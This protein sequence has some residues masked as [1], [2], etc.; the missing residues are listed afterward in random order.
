MTPRLSGLA[1]MFEETSEVASPARGVGRPRSSSALSGEKRSSMGSSRSIPRAAAKTPRLTGVRR[2][3]KT[4][5]IVKS[6][7]LSGVRQVLRS[8][9]VLA[10]PSMSG[11][12]RLLE[13]PKLCVS[14]RLSG[15]A[16]LLPFSPESQKTPAAS[17]IKLIRKASRRQMAVS[18]QLVRKRALPSTISSDICDVPPPKTAK[19]TS[20]QTVLVRSTRAGSKRPPK[21]TSN[22]VALPLTSS[23]ESS[24]A[25]ARQ[26]SRPKPVRAPAVDGVG[27]PPD[28]SNKTKVN[29][30]PAATKPKPARKRTPVKNAPLRVTRQRRA[31]IEVNK[32]VDKPKE[33]PSSPTRQGRAVR[34][35]KTSTTKR[36]VSKTMESNTTT[37]I[38]KVLDSPVPSVRTNRKRKSA[39]STKVQAKKPRSTART[40]KKT[41]ASLSS[42][43]HSHVVI[44]PRRT[45][46]ANRIRN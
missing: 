33:E 21:S 44:S 31:L 5:K 32:A 12:R 9:R 27:S 40:T 41:T 28:K 11:L 22:S 25:T 15:L 35:K 7:R 39:P 34:I 10:S 8:P 3:W 19:D 29:A 43:V 17:G 37:T 30:I 4:P 1:G 14:P 16:D 46:A 20:L 42:P 23:T 24:R 26:T 38:T 6:P 2:L 18:S 13:S 45:R 36:S